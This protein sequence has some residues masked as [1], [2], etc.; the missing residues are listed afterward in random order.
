MKTSSF[1]LCMTLLVSAS[2]AFAPIASNK[3]S[4]TQ[5][6]A[7]SRREAL[8][9]IGLALGGLVALPGASNAVNNPALQTFKGRK[10]TKGQFTPGKGLRNH[11][12]MDENWVALK[13]P[14]LETFKGG[15]KTKGE[16]IPGK[17]LRMKDDE[18]LALKNPALETFKGGKKTKGEFI[19]GKGLRM[20]EEDFLALKNPA[21]ETFKGG[22]KTK[23]EFIP[24]KGL[25]LNESFE[26]L[27]G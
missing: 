1:A 19:P 2:D 8:S 5:L 15:K 24:G 4:S 21:L 7:E 11:E 9:A 10:P 3:L 20:R 6:N 27:M 18:L 26:S 12:V 13:N 23:G 22:K 17:G 14:A 16:F 25:R